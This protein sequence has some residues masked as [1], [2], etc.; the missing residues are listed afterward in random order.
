MIFYLYLKIFFFFATENKFQ[1][2]NIIFLK[3]SNLTSNIICNEQIFPINFIIDDNKINLAIIEP[4]KK[5]LIKKMTNFY[6]INNIYKAILT[7]K[8][9]EQ[10]IRISTMQKAEKNT[11]EI[12]NN[13]KN[14]YNKL[15]HLKITQEILENSSTREV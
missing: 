9:T 7:A 1:K 11:K 2:I 3:N 8:I 13:L 12:I 15:R 6:A 14:K 5:E 10:T 4:N